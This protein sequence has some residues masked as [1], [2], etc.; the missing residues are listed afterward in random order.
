M[1]RT[2]CTCDAI[3]TNVNEDPYPARWNNCTQQA[4]TVIIKQLATQWA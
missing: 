1:L 2:K 3:E 4:D